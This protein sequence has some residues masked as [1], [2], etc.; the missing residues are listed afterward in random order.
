MRHTVSKLANVIIVSWLTC[1][2]LVKP[3]HAD[4]VI[5]TL[6]VGSAPT[7]IAVNTTTGL[8]SGTPAALGT[9]TAM[10]TAT[11]P[12]GMAT[13]AVTITISNQP[14]PTAYPFSLSVP[15]NTPATYDLTASVSGSYTSVSITSQVSHGT[16]VVNGLNVT[17][18][19]FPGYFGPDSFAFTAIGPG[20]ASAVRARHR[21]CSPHRAD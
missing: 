14:T 11:N 1:A 12:S 18:T 16:L 8:I 21:F 20:G 9:T 10:V 4:A 7:A 15:F 2:A 19:P 6:P 5:A 13:K 3:A 17:Y